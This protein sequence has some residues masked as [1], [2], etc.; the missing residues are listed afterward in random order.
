MTAIKIQVW[1][2]ASMAT[3]FLAIA[4]LGQPGTIAS[5]LPVILVG[6][7]YGPRWGLTAGLLSY[8]V[9]LLGLWLTQGSAKVFLTDVGAVVGTIAAVGVGWLVG[10]ATMLHRAAA[11]AR[12]HA[13]AQLGDAF[14]YAPIGMAIVSPTGDFERVNA[15]FA[16]MLTRP[17]D[18]LVRLNWRDISPQREHARSRSGI[19]ALFNGTTDRVEMERVFITADG[20]ERIGVA[21]LSAVRDPHGQPVHMLAQMLDITDLRQANSQLRDLLDSKDRFLAAISHELR[22]PLSAVNGLAYEL[23]DSLGDFSAAE[24]A[25]FAGVI[26]QQSTELTG[27]VEDFLVHARADTDQIRVRRDPVVLADEA[28]QTLSVIQASVP[29]EIRLISA[30]EPVV[31]VADAFRVR[32]IVRNLLQNALRYGGPTISI[33]TRHLNGHSTL[34][35][36]DDGSGVE[37][38]RLDTVFLPYE[39]SQPNPGLTE[40]L[41]VG[42]YISRTLAQLMG[43]DL[44]YHRDVAKTHFQLSLPRHRAPEQTVPAG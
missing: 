39:R 32:Q 15:A 12:D 44:T 26:A 25:E 43:G 41:G 6:V 14:E 22:T 33:A 35:V 31:A 5:V 3:Y 11:D 17:Q 42:L 24:I 37:D 38:H 29:T 16:E 20:T 23:R 7:S 18:Q 4:F 27:L 13:E 28:A 36:T 1:A 34:T 30:D 10:Y 8:P 9:N 19:E 40:S 2:I 21:H